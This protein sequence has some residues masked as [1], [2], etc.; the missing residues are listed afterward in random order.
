MVD[1]KKR[2]N[3]AII[4]VVKKHD[5][6]NKKIAEKLGF[7]EETVGAYRNMATDPKLKFIIPFCDVYNIDFLWFSRGDGE[8]FHR[9]RQ[10]FPE[11]CGPDESR[12]IQ[13]ALED[14][15]G[16]P[17]AHQV[18][19]APRKGKGVES[20]V[21][22]E[23]P[24]LYGKAHEQAGFLLANILSSG[25][26]IMIQAILSNLKA[27]NQAIETQQK[28]KI[29]IAKLEKTCEDFERRVAVLEEK[30]KPDHPEPHAD[31]VL[32]QSAAT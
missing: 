9:A 21:V 18:G 28:D 5:L 19:P 17:V 13:D 2:A 6:S 12:Y 32:K 27:F 23:S 26:Q 29:R 10:Q 30:H 7:G 16:L 1:L 4:Y 11:I 22:R 24:A 3:W 15:E 31:A 25:D 8:P 20:P 14:L